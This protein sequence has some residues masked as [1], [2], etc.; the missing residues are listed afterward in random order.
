MTRSRNFE[1]DILDRITRI[2]QEHHELICPGLEVHEEYGFS[3]SFRRGSNSKVQNRGVN[4]RVL[5][6]TIVGGRW[7]R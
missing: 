4:D 5:I 1:V 2:Q 3:R 7:R 6:G